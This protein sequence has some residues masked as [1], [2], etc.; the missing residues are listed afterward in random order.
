M[1]QLWLEIDH[2]GSC[3]RGSQPW[4]G[5]RQCY[6]LEIQSGGEMT[7]MTGMT[8]MTLNPGESKK[9]Q[10]WHW[11]SV[12]FSQNSCLFLQALPE[13]QIRSELRVPLERKFI[14]EDNYDPTYLWYLAVESS[15]SNVILR[16]R[17]PWRFCLVVHRP[18]QVYTLIHLS[19]QDG[20]SGFSKA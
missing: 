3:W 18:C 15:R 9:F 6:D 10:L 20:G 1:Q 17:K 19:H 14:N 12:P 7:G 4:S 8:G 13:K 11:I 16:L 2:A 5:S